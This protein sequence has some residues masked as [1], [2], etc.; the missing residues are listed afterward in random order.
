MSACAINIADWRAERHPNGNLAYT[1]SKSGLL[2]LTRIAAQDLAPRVRVNAIAPGPMLPPP[3]KDYSA[4][5][6]VVRRLPLQRQG[7]P[8]DIAGAVRFL[9]E[10][11]FITGEMLHVDGGQQFTGGL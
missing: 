9:V 4:I 5:E 3:G 6:P 2:A 1:V 11:D 10:S 8:E 7:S